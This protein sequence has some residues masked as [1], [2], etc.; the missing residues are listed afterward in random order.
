MGNVFVKNMSEQEFYW[1]HS[2]NNLFTVQ[3]NT[4]YRVVLCLSPSLQGLLVYPP[5]LVPAEVLCQFSNVCVVGKSDVLGWIPDHRRLSGVKP[6]HAA[7]KEDASLDIVASERVLGSDVMLTLYL[8]GKTNG[9]LT[10]QSTEGSDAMCRGVAV[11]QRHQEDEILSARLRIWHTSL[12][13]GHMLQDD[14]EHI[15]GHCGLRFTDSH[16]C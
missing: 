3:L 12:T 14:S 10:E 8:L 15:C 6:A 13:H 1:L 2:L 7:A 9:S 16:T 5:V 4:T 11:L